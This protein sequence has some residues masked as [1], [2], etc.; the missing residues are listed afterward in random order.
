[1]PQKDPMFYD[2]C[3]EAYS[4]PELAIEPVSTTGEKLAKAVRGSQKIQVDMPI[5]MATPGAAD[6]SDDEPWR[7][8]ERE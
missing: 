1:M 5:T 4:V 3:L 2:S 8:I 6:A 7:H